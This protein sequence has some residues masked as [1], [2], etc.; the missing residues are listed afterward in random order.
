[1]SAGQAKSCMTMVIL[2]GIAFLIGAAYLLSSPSRYV[3]SLMCYLAQLALLNAGEIRVSESLTLQYYELA[4]LQAIWT[5]TKVI[6]AFM[7]LF[8]ILAQVLSALRNE[9]ESV[10]E[11]EAQTDTWNAQLQEAMAELRA[12]AAEE[13]A[14]SRAETEAFRRQVHAVIDQFQA[15]LK[16]EARARFGAKAALE[17]Q[18]QGKSK[19]PKRS[20][21]KA[22]LI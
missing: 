17:A 6:Y 14:A 2:V 1:M 3:W 9:S 5:A 7:A 4:G 18:R 11:L 8:M 10:R 15:R 13:H 12:A 16:V 22:Y 21:S 19:A 20:G